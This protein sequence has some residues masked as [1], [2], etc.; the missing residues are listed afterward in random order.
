M[1]EEEKY[2]FINFAFYP[3]ASIKD[4]KVIGSVTFEEMY[5]AFKSRLM[6][7]TSVVE[8]MTPEEFEEWKKRMVIDKG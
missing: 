3:L 1:T 6:H 7:E 8:R 2:K 4:G 5:Q